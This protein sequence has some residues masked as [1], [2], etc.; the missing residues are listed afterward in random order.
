MNL[1]TEILQ[2]QNEGIASVLCSVVHT[3]GSTPRKIGAKMLVKPNGEIIGTIGGGNLEKKVIENALHQLQLKEAKIFKHDLLHQ[4][5]MCCGGTVE[6]YIEPILPMK[7]LYI[8]GAGHTGKALAQYST[9]LDF[10]TYII[11]DRKDYI[12]ELPQLNN[13]NKLHADYKKLLP[14]LPFNNNTYI[15]ILTY[16]HEIDRDILSYCIKQPHAYIGMIGSQRKIEMTKKI[17]LD[18]SICNQEKLNT[19]NMPIGINIAAETPEEIA[20]S[21]LAKLIE[22]KNG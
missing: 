17:F 16:E 18:A 3:K 20:I 15:V 14:T 22:V 19:I 8:F 5:N 12:E 13:I 21:I 9:S 11:D 6:I 2:L 4:H 7:K 10:D 1:Y